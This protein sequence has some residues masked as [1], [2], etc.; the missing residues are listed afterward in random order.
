MAAAQIP[1][2]FLAERLGEL[3]LLGLGTAWYSISYVTVAA[4]VGFTSL[5]LLMVSAGA[6]TAIGRLNFFGDVGKVAFP[7]LAGVLVAAVGWRGTFTGLGCL[8]LAVSAAFLLYFRNHIRTRR[9]R[10]PP[11]AKSAGWGIVHRSKFSRYAAIGFLDVAV[12]TAVVTFLGFQL[13]AVGLDE[14]KL[15]WMIS[16]TFLG[17]PSASSCAG[18]WSPAWARE[19]SSYSPSW[20][21][22]PAASFSPCTM[23][24]GSWCCSCRCSVS[25]STAPR[26]SSTSALRRPLPLPTAAADTPSISPSTS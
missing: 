24:A 14:S 20:A 10:R 8:G 5:F 22:S 25:S 9:Q 19:P 21:R 17:G 1:A 13:L 23:P 12:R 2:G 4:A 7:A 16:L 26:P 18:C 15:G 3:L 11:A 6:G